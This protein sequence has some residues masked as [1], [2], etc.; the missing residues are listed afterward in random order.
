MLSNS[1]TAVRRTVRI[2]ARLTHGEDA[3]QQ[4]CVLVDVSHTGARLEVVA[5]ADV[6]DTFT[7]VFTPRGVP[8]RRCVVIWRGGTQIGVSFTREDP[9][10]LGPH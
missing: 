2:P 9:D 6:P 4:E 3:P 1:R 5:A 7:M 8:L 10:P